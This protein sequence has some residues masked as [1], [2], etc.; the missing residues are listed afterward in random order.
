M[1]KVYRGPFEKAW[2]GNDFLFSQVIG[3]R[4]SEEDEKS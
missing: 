2:Q 4:K 3:E 1:V